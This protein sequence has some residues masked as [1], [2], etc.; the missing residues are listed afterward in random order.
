MPIITTMS[1][2][3]GRIRRPKANIGNAL[4]WLDNLPSGM[5]SLGAYTAE[6]TNFPE[7]NWYFQGFG[8]SRVS[9][10]SG[11]RGSW[12]G[13]FTFPEGGFGNGAGVGVLRQDQM[14]GDV[15][16][17]RAYWCFRHKFSSNYVLNKGGEK[18]L[19]PG[20]LPDTP[21]QSPVFQLYAE[22]ELTGGIKFE[23]IDH[24]VGSTLISVGE[25]LLQRGVWQTIEV[26]WYLN[27]AGNADGYVKCWVDGV[28][29]VNRTGVQWYLGT[30][31]CR[32]WKPVYDTTRGGGAADNPVPTGGMTREID[33]LVAYWGN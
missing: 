26:D 28:L 2:P 33:E 11:G 30:N 17:R 20:M 16:Y 21:T 5:T 3:Q 24:T 14:P 4:N 12:V 22:N 10:S 7:N 9:D 1:S 15:T 27:S 18:M 13:R 32:F 19:Y 23:L 25:A 31:E 6:N 8:T 29:A